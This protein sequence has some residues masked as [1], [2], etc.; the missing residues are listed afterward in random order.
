MCAKS[1]MKTFNIKHIQA[2]EYTEQKDSLV[3]MKLDSKKYGF[4]K[5][6]SLVLEIN[7]I[8]LFYHCSK[9]LLSMFEPSTKAFFFLDLV[10]V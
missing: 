2:E 1:Y 9:N 7:F 4:C 3:H 10:E 8:F 6:L 5:C